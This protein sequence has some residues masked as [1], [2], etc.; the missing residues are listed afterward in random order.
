MAIQLE[1]TLYNGQTVGYHRISELK[2]EAD[3]TGL[4]KLESFA[5]RQERERVG[6]SLFFTWY[7]VAWMGNLNYL[8]DAYAY[9]MAL[10]EFAGAQNV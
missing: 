7:P 8:G 9:L 1:K 5:D 6:A 10:P 4:V 3:L 2:I